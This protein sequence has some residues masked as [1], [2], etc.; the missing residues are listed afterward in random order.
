[1]FVSKLLCKYFVNALVKQISP[2]VAIIN[3]ASP[4]A[5]HDSQFNRDID[6]TPAGPVVKMILRRVGN[7]SAVGARMITD[8]VAHHGEDTHG[9]FLSFQKLVPMPPII[10]TDE[11][12]NISGQLWKETMDELS[13]ANTATIVEEMNK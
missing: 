11:G 5:I 13:F 9:Q 1:M 12:A 8:A 10:Y 6:K 2:L 4:G 7:S 3:A